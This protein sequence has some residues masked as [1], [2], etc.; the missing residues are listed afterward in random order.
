MEAYSR[1]NLDFI[2]KEMIADIYL[3]VS[4]PAQIDGSS[5]WRQEE[6]CRKW[7]KDNNIEVRHVIKD[8]G[9]AFGKMKK[10]Q[11]ELW[12]ACDRW[13]KSYWET[14]GEP[15]AEWECPKNVTGEVPPNFLVFESMDRFSRRPLAE[16]VFLLLYLQGIKIQPICTDEIDFLNH[17]DIM[18]K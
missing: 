1:I 18:L 10:G 17:F 13:R 5:F 11:K 2:G 15:L 3:R 6:S 16:V 4:T 7:C 12:G 14:K 9:S 8:I